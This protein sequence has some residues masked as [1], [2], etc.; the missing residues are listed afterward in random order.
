M[1]RNKRGYSLLILFILA[2]YVGVSP[3]FAQTGGGLHF[4]ETDHW[5]YG[6]FLTFYLK[7]EN[8]EL[9]FG[10]PMTEEFISRPPNA[11]A[12]LLV[13]YFNKVRFEFHPEFPEGQRVVITKLGANYRQ[14]DVEVIIAPD[15]PSCRQSINWDYPVCYSFLEFF[16]ANGQEIILGK[17]I[18][19]MEVHGTRVLQFF[20]NARLEW[21]P[22]APEGFQIISAD[23][24]SK[25]FFD[26]DEDMNRLGTIPG[27][28]THLLVTSI[29]GRAFVDQAIITFKGKQIFF[30][31]A[32][33]QNNIPIN[34]AE[35]TISIKHPSGNIVNLY[36]IRTDSN[37]LAAASYQLDE[38]TIGTVQ[39]VITIEFGDVVKKIE[40]SYRV[41]Y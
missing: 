23:L 19:H 8:P 31:T 17:P 29:H 3:A 27:A 36:N 21:H 18:S 38:G 10:P 35:I 34:E 37:G 24:G 28:F 12:G 15:H 33:N 13:Q 20:E 16:E 25:Y 11:S 26:R 22:N 41:W 6:A 5:V 39:A 40:V 14:S 9:V 2:V 32:K 4:R 7:A 1:R 30:I